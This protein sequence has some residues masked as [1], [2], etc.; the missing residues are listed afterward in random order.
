ML[1]YCI[2]RHSEV[3]KLCEALNTHVF[4]TTQLV[5]DYVKNKFVGSGLKA[6]IHIIML[7]QIHTDW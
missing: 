3:E 7:A 6:L 1:Y 4:L 2:K 5:I